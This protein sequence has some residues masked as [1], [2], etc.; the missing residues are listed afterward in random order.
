MFYLKQKRFQVDRR[1]TAVFLQH[2]LLKP[3]KAKNVKTVIAC[4]MKTVH[5]KDF[6]MA[7][8][9]VNWPFPTHLVIYSFLIS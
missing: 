4:E 9:F 3:Y 1:F 8:L 6:L 5:D 2:H 7:L